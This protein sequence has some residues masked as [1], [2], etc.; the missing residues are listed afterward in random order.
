MFVQNISVER[1]AIYDYIS[2]QN[3]VVFYIFSNNCLIVLSL[4]V[5]SENKFYLKYMLVID[6]GMRAHIS[7]SY[8]TNNNYWHDI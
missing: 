3:Y 5:K 1:T 7:K 4:S 6:N 2:I 8:T